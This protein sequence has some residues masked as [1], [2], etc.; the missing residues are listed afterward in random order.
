MKNR[1]Y[2]V[3]HI[4]EVG[5]EDT[6]QGYI[7]I[8]KNTLKFRFSQHATSK[9]PIGTIIRSGIPLE[10]V[11]LHKVPLEDAFYYEG[12][13]RPRMN[14]GWNVMAGGGRSAPE[15]RKKTGRNCRFPSG[16]EP[17]NYGKGEKYKLV[18][19]EGEEFIPEAFTVFCRERGLN[20]QNLR[21]VAKGLRKHSSGW[22][23]TRLNG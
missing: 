6:S 17:H 21:K 22:K 5:N 18:S 16:H 11:C 10:I 4:R 13:Y 3:Y 9:R 8:T 7:G 2:S 12:V 20:P 15:W 23:A 14:I 1:L 19:P